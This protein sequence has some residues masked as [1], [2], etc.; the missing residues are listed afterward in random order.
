MIRVR[1]KPAAAENK[2]TAPERGWRS[3]GGL[4]RGYEDKNSS[5]PRPLP[6]L[7]KRSAR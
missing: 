7:T 3:A 2:K 4:G 5:K 1:I 6:S